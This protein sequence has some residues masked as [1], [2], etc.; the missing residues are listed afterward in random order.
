[1]LIINYLREITIS[2]VPC[3]LFS[4]NSQVNISQG[5]EIIMRALTIF[6]QFGS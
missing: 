5:N 3:S 1:M 6:A 2:D 4:N